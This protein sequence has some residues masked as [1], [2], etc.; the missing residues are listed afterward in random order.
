MNDIFFDTLTRGT[1]APQ[2]RRVAL[3]GLGIA[4]LGAMA[5]TGL[6]AEAK[7]NGKGANQNKKRRHRGGAEQECP[8]E[9][10][11]AEAQQAVAVTCQAQVTQCEQQFREV[12]RDNDDPDEEAECLNAFLPC[13]PPLTTCDFAGFF[14]CLFSKLV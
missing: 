8:P 14:T 7:N 11:T 13:C 9:D 12:C 2:G 4:A 1:Q 6:T 10:C 5:G 3:K